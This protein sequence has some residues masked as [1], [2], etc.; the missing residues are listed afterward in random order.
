MQSDP[1]AGSGCIR[2]LLDDAQQ[3]ERQ[4]RLAEATRLYAEA[5]EAAADAPAPL[6]EALRRLGRAQYRAQQVA[7]AEASLRRSRAV[8]EAAGETA[9]AAEALNA[10]GI[11]AIERGQIGEAAEL[12]AGALAAGGHVVP[13]RALIE[14]NLGIVANIRGDVRSAVT[15]YQHSL[16]AFEASGDERG[17]ALAYHNLGM[18]SADLK[19]W[20]DADRHFRESLAI[21][22]RHDDAYLRGLCLL[23]HTEV[24]LAHRR[25]DEARRNAEGAL[26]IFDRLGARAYKS[27]AYRVLGVVYRETGRHALAEARLGDAIRLA[28]EADSALN[29]AD[30]SRELALLY[31]AVGRNQE[32]LR[33]L[34][35][36][37]RLFRRLGARVDMV[38]I[39]ARAAELEGA[40]HAV[41]REWGQSIESADSYTHG[42]CERVATYAV[43]V[44]RAL[45][46]ADDDLTTIRL[47]AYLHDVGKVR[48][49]HE[50]LN[51]PG[52]LTDEEFTVLKQHTIWGVELLASVEFPWDIKPIIRSHHERLDGTGYPD[53]LKG[54]EIPLHAQVIC[55]ADV[56][57]ALTTTR[58]YRPAMT[59]AAAIA[60]MDRTRH[61]WRAD[62]YAAF[63][64]TVGRGA[65]RDDGGGAAPGEVAQ[66]G[67]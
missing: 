60:E 38:D 17:C 53:R 21:A 19:R 2:R 47:G 63:M 37:R 14:Q 4:G 1:G 66:E 58:S 8:A 5:V 45:G 67:A 46:L 13:L 22:E 62:V 28:V 54:D 35:T 29:E 25:H 33:L 41:V 48:V 49:P 40:Y 55:M 23:N 9:L 12:L 51:K 20:D 65:A 42:H 10:L 52:R 30:A 57:D 56:Y 59:H 3:H 26:R 50:I 43:A 34:N 16:R 24:L 36:A 27:G 44:A 32:A 61:W 6:A 7:A 39:T 11:L 31:V 18:L 64:G 15:H